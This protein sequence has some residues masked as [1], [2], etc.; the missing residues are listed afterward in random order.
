MNFLKFLLSKQFLKN[1]LIAVIIGIV[2]LAST[3]LWLKIYTRHGKTIT[4]PDLSGLTEEEVGI[5]TESK[6]LRFEIVDSIF[7]KELPRGTVAKQNPR[8]GS[9]VKQ[10]RRLYLTMN[11]VNP[12]K[13]TMPAV[14]GVSLRQA[15]AILE[16][17]GLNLGKISYKPD[18]AVNV[19]LE[20]NYQDTIAKPGMIIVKGA[21]I[22]LVL[23][24][25]LSNETTAVPNLTG[26]DLLLAKEFL[27]DRYLNIGAIIYDNT[28]EDDEDSTAAF[29]WK[30][31]PEFENENK[32]QL[33]ENVDIWLTVD[34]TK[35]PQPDSLELNELDEEDF[36][37][38]IFE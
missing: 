26:F 3:F 16:T 4:V 19:V 30:Q 7:Y 14:T 31:R 5:I 29:V 25:G 11:A 9:K 6:S 38:D 35:L 20:Q 1:L 28:I 23:G 10:N 12:E 17:Y 27:A 37:E 24:K 2:L 33:G 15:R 18:I 22:D 34:S 13:V 32:L 36:I 8:P 21:E